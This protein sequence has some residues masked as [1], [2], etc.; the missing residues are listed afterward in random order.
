MYISVQEGAFRANPTADP[1]NVILSTYYARG[2]FELLR[3]RKARTAA[4]S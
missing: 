4:S 2:G 3:G 1:V